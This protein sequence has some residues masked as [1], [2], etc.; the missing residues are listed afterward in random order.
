MV[1]LLSTPTPGRTPA[2]LADQMAP[3]GSGLAPDAIR[4]PA[5]SPASIFPARPSTNPSPGVVE[6][7]QYGVAEDVATFRSTGFKAVRFDP[8][9]APPYVIS[10]IRF[11]SL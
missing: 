7:A 3:N 11:P 5:A 2:A 8:P 6:I 1:I 10:K 4:I 9:F